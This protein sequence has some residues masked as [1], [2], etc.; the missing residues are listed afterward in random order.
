MT[1]RG[2]VGR[3]ICGGVRRCRPARRD[4]GRDIKACRYDDAGRATVRQP[5]TAVLQSACAGPVGGHLLPGYA[6]KL[7][8]PHS[9]SLART[10][11][12]S[13]ARARR[14]RLRRRRRPPD[15][16][17]LILVVHVPHP[18]C[19]HH[20]RDPGS[21]PDDGRQREARAGAHGPVPDLT[22]A[23]RG[24]L[25]RRAGAQLDAPRFHSV[26]A[27]TDLSR[28][29]T[30]PAAESPQSRAASRA[31]PSVADGSGTAGG[32][33]KARSQ[34]SRRRAMGAQPGHGMARS[35]ATS[36]RILKEGT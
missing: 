1:R 20:I 19:P 14:R 4:A 2:P 15:P 11:T 12:K 32:P 22:G 18:C 17:R 24:R 8:L 31:T 13:A 34:W 16:D 35:P 26:S 7:S 33:E 36:S 30:S 3:T 21:G 25:G 29:V 9:R 28:L 5:A 6:T 23:A 27:V 10:L